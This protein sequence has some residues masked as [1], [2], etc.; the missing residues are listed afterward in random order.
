MKKHLLAIA[1]LSVSVGLAAC[2]SNK[3]V[4]TTEATTESTTE[5]ES[6]EVSATVETSESAAESTEAFD[7]QYTEGEITAI[8]GDQITVN[9]EFEEVTLKFDLSDAKITKTFPL[10]VGDYVEVAYPENAEGDVIKAEQLEVIDSVL[11][12]SEEPMLIGTVTEAGTG[13]LTIETEDGETYQ[14]ETANAYVVAAKG[15]EAGKEVQVNYLGDAGFDD[16][17][18]ATKIVTEDSYDDPKAKINAFVGTV[19]SVEEHGLV[20][21]SSSGDYYTFVSPNLDFTQFEPGQTVQVT[22]T[23]SLAG[24]EISAEAVEKK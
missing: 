6:V 2:T 14:F 4:E 8:D 18:T 15:V 5:A 19:D 17:L 3:P 23:G 16:A 13:T 11:A 24:K 12:S 9:D 22:Y 20:L 10:S 1:L 21:V 7:L